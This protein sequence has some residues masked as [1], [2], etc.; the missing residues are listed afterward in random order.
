[1]AAAVAAAFLV[2][3]AVVAL[4]WRARLQREGREDFQIASSQAEQFVIDRMRDAVT[5][6]QDTR[7][8]VSGDQPVTAGSFEDT[9][10]GALPDQ[11]LAMVTVTLVEPV[12][13][14][15]VAAFEAA[16]RGAGLPGFRVRSL[17]PGGAGPAVATFEASTRGA[18]ILSGYDLRI[19]P[20]LAEAFRV[21]DPAPVQVTP[22]LTPLP[23]EVLRV[24]PDLGQTGFALVA[25]TTRGR[26]VVGVLSG[27]E[28]ARAASAAVEGLDVA[29]LLD[30]RPLGDS[31]GDAGVTLDLTAVADEAQS[32]R[33]F[34]IAGGP[35]TVAVADLD[36]IA[37]GGWREPGMLLG[38]GAALSVLV[39]SLIL[40]LARGRAGAMR[41]AS[42]AQEAHA[43]SEQNFRAVV[44]HLSDLVVLA[45]GELVVSFVTPSVAT[46]LGR[47]PTAVRDRSLID[48]VHPDDRRLLSSLTGTDGV[49]DTALIRFRHSDGEYRSFEVVVANRLEDPAIGGLVLTGH[50]VTD[51]V[52]LEH[53]LSHDATHDALTNLPNRALIM[54][55]LGHALARADR[56]GTRVAVV[57]ADLDDFKDVN[58]DYGHQVGDRLLA[59]VARRLGSAA[60]AMDT[61]GRYAGD[62]F[63]VICEEVD[64]EQAAL[65]IAH[66]L[67]TEA[68]RPIQAEGT[69]VTVTMS[70]GVA[71]AA[72]DETAD[73]LIGRADRAMYE[74]KAGD[75][76][77]LAP[78]PEES[79][80]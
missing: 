44:Q 11:S 26:W 73:H 46:L 5:V 49:S 67:Y 7:A 17:E 41:E 25:P 19:T 29:L 32:E 51:R 74:A 28:L 37:G 22:L 61:V 14:S 35:L 48:L 52:H 43:R 21:S 33:P 13:R 10:A 59:T 34:A 68:A 47:D 64:G 18:P 71:L 40:V 8:S 23:A 70:L 55:R 75:A 15:E 12:E 77:C 54:D 58:D 57:F 20:A 62:E 39:G 80:A 56:T 76:V 79:A 24:H 9:V 65:Q 4:S 31:T 30:D 1:V 3:S 36:G 2:L 42:V 60:R 27:E 45:D 72:R 66:R 6:L 38:A 63:V 16:H 69:D 53:R 50:D 78:P